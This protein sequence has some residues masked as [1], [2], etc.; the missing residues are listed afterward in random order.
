MLYDLIVNKFTI[1][2]LI[3]IF[4]RLI[5]SPFTYHSD[6]Q[7]FDLGGYVLTKDSP[8][9][10]YDYLSSLPDENR[11]SKTFNNFNFN[12][13]PAVHLFLGSFAIPLSLVVGEEFR[14]DFLTNIKST[15]GSPALFFHLLTLKIPYLAFD[16]GLAY[17]LMKLFAERKEKFLILCLWMFN[18]VD[19]Y[20][21]YM[22]GQF[23]IIPT[24]FAVLSIYFIAISQ[25]LKFTSFASISL[26][27]GAAFKIYPLFLLLP[28]AF[29]RK[30]F[31]E[32]IGIFLLGLFP[33]F[34]LILPF[35]GSSG[36]RNSALV[37]NQTLKSFYAAIPISGGESIL[38][39]PSFLIFLY[40]FL[41]IKG[42]ERNNLWNVFLIVLLSFFVFTHFHPQWLLWAT[43]FL[44]IHLV[45]S[46]F[47][48][49]IPLVIILI[50]WFVS[51]FFFDPGLTLGLFSPIAPNLYDSKSLWQ[52]FG[53]YIDYNFTRSI[54]Q[55]IF[56][57]SSIYYFY[58]F[59][60]KKS[61]GNV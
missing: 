13:P 14:F 19:I 2:L 35:F 52:I 45:R 22:M 21:T 49:L 5:I 57:A 15:L 10:F 26:G 59:F 17:F 32:R 9:N 39:F 42:V 3:G 20:A 7:V 38:L 50:S 24:F 58:S 47:E 23:D 6:I 61:L 31:F 55:S 34:I 1:V 11:I 46:K 40:I 18:P 12:Y 48:S 28:L 4:L 29:I 36:F 54:I 25:N 30:R 41:F 37:A 16:L 51:L 56:V 44:A 43:P 60:S 33:Y 8:I 27:V 53:I